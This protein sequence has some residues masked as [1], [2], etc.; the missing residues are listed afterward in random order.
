[1]KR[2]R[3]GFGLRTLFIVTAA[4]WWGPPAFCAERYV[5]VSGSDAAPG[6]RAKPWR[7]L[8][9]AAAT[10][11]A[12]DTV[13]VGKGRYF[14]RV[15][16]TNSGTAERPIIFRPLPGHAPV[17]DGTD[18]AQWDGFVNLAGVDHVRLEGLT[19]TNCRKGQAVYVIHRGTDPATHIELRKLTID[20]VADS[21]V[22][23]RGNAHHVL[24]EG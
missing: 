21:P 16:F 20:H 2:P 15:V 1:M 24:V 7:T 9:K 13:H 4:L 23:I 17:L 18:K 10:A 19:I 12:G 6:T 5:E 22:Q 14:E 11:R 3:P 8:S